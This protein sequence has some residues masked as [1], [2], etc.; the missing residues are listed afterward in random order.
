MNSKETNIEQN[1]KEV[2]GELTSERTRDRRVYSPK[3]DIWENEEGLK[4]Y[5]EMPGTDEQNVNITLEKNVLTME[6]RVDLPDISNHRIGHA[7]YGVGDY[8]RSF[9]L[10]DEIDKDKISASMQ[11]GVLVLELP[12]AEPAKARKIT[13]KSS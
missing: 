6:G 2:T 8:S 10:S 4:M 5:V 1:K 7:E 3:V 11:D 9:T 13:I 12:K